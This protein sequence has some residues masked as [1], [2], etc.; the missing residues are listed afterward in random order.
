MS[1]DSY[2]EL[3]GKRLRTLSIEE[4]KKRENIRPFGQLLYMRSWIGDETTIRVE[5]LLTI[6]VG[7]RMKLHT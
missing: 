3:G 7:K 6:L 1:Y 4:R 2:L 5:V